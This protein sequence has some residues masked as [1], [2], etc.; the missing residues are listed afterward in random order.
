M[1]TPAVKFPYQDA[2]LSPDAR[3]RDLVARMTLEDKA[4]AMFQTIVAVGPI[5]Q[6]MTAFGLPSLASIAINH[7]ISYLYVVGNANDSREFARWI[8]SAQDLVARSGLGIPITFSTDPRHGFAENPGSAM[9][10]SMFSLWPESIGLAALRS[11]ELVERFADI[12]RQ[13]Y[14][15]VGL[16]SALHPQIDVATEPRWSRAGATFGEDAHLTAEL[17]AAYVRGLQ[18]AKLGSTSVSA[19]AKHFPGGGPQKDGEDPHFTYGKEQVYPGGNFRYHLEPFVA[20]IEAGVAEIMPYYGMPVGTEYD[21]VGFAFDK[22]I[23]TELLRDQLGFD[24]VVCTDFGLLTD[25][26][27][28]GSD[29]PARAWGLE[30]KT[31]Q[32]RILRLLDAGVDQFGGELCTEELIAA[33]RL[34]KVAESRLDVSVV[35]LMRQK[36]ELGLFENAYADEEQAVAIAGNAAFRAEGDRAQRAAMTLLTNG[37]IDDAPA[38]PVSGSLRVYAVIRTASPHETRGI[39]FEAFFHAG[40]LEFP[41]EEAAR[42]GAIC[43]AVPT[44][45]DITLDRATILGDLVESAA[46]IIADYGASDQA[47]LD[48]LTGRAHPEGRLPFDLPSSMEAVRRS[49]ED[50]PFDTQAPAFRFGHGLAYADT[51]VAVE[52]AV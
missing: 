49:R 19:M 30:T 17:A 31:R 18:G 51:T 35:R 15:S 42:L 1:N 44:I 4:G 38:L 52:A 43:D 39:G 47:V 25:V 8:N 7:R 36:F 32:E 11:P 41:A 40:S 13:E 21:E 29:M 12:V 3:A 28:M 16:R 20:A 5:D 14:V 37:T 6:P 50:V 10:S 27:I 24:G 23:V 33:V 45:I 34:G 26:V 2:T 22:A 48:V 9:L 46:A